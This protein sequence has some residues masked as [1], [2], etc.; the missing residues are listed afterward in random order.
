MMQLESKNKLVWVITGFSAL[1]ILTAPFQ[2]PIMF[3]LFIGSRLSSYILQALPIGVDS[4]NNNDKIEQLELNMTTWKQTP[5]PW[6]RWLS[7]WVKWIR[8]TIQSLQ[9][10][11]VIEK[12]S[13]WIARFRFLFVPTLLYYLHRIVLK[14]YLMRLSKLTEQLNTI[15]L[16]WMLCINAITPT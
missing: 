8:E 9:K 11:S 16:H 5:I 14:L 1:Y 6:Q 3:I 4:L 10:M 13:S 15:V 7:T 2:K 12:I